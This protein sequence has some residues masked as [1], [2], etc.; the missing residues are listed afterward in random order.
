MYLLIEG[1]HETAMLRLMALNGE[2]SGSVMARA[3]IRDAAKEAGVWPATE[4]TQ[5]DVCIDD[6][7]HS[8]DSLRLA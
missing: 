1:I 6:N 4:E 3:L 7:T 8:A 5:R 2:K